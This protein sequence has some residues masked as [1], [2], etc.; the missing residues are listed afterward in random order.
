VNRQRLPATAARRLLALALFLWAGALRAES[1][2]PWP[3]VAVPPHAKVEWVADN[4]KVNGFPMR[5]LHFEST[6]SREE[7]VN[8]Y[9]AH[10]SGGYPTK[11][12][13]RTQDGTTIVG[14]AHGPYFMTA[15]VSDAPHSGSQGF[16]SISQIVGNHA[17]RSAGPLP[18]PPGA[19]ILTVVESSDPGKQSRQV[20]AV[21]RAGVI[22]GAN[23]FQAALEGAGWHLVQRTQADARTA[24]AGLLQIFQRDQD[25]V[26]VS[27]MP[28]AQRG[29]SVVLN[30]VTKGTGRGGD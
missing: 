19:T 7:V 29:S 8:F 1:S 17:E 23:W 2:T 4:M 12:A 25:E 18:L 5:V 16:L 13:V 28:G 20:T 9:T 11:P 22:A 15:K 14:Q 30:L 6:A 24:D 10:W 21:E 26:S 27:V 3:D